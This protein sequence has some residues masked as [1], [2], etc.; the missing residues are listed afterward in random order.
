MI[1]KIV[2]ALGLALVIVGTT[3]ALVTSTA[4]AAPRAGVTKPAARPATK[5]AALPWWIVRLQRHPRSG[6]CDLPFVK[7]ACR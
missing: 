1:R 7:V 6:P 4:Q 2:I 3:G 5:D